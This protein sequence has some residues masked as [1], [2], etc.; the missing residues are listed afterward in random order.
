LLIGASLGISIGIAYLNN[1]KSINTGVSMGISM[2][3]TCIN[4]GIQMSLIKL[5]YH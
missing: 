3:V 2:V 1:D 5:S 4:I